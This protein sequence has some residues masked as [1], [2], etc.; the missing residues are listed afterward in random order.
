MQC[1]VLRWHRVL[2][3]CYAVS[4]S[5]LAYCATRRRSNRRVLNFQRRRY[6]LSHAMSDTGIAYAVQ[7]P[8]VAVLCL[9]SYAPPTKCPVLTSGMVLPGGAS[10]SRRAYAQGRTTPEG[11]THSL[12]S[13]Q[14]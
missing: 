4:G 8:Q 13:A 7:C 9:W 12:G 2:C 11:P 6:P 3:A 14:Y 1:P 10:R 5:N